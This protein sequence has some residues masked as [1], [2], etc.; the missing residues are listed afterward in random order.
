MWLQH[1]LL[2][3]VVGELDGLELLVDDRGGGEVRGLVADERR[4][5]LRQERTEVL[6]TMTGTISAASASTQLR[7]SALSPHKMVSLPADRQ[8]FAS[9]SI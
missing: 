8:R 6:R 3:L 7:C 1:S 4:A 5:G 9:R 2:A